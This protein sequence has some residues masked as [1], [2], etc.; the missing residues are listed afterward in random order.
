MTSG[1]STPWM[2][3]QLVEI[4]HQQLALDM[5]WAVKYAE[6]EEERKSLDFGAFVRIAPATVSSRKSVP[7]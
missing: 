3:G 7:S 4:L 6:G 1:L 2:N 5:D